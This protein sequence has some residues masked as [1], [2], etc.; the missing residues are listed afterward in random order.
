MIFKA[1]TGQKNQQILSSM[2]GKTLLDIQKATRRTPNRSHHRN[3]AKV[4]L[5]KKT[6]LHMCESHLRLESLGR[7]KPVCNQQIVFQGKFNVLL[8]KQ[9]LK[10]WNIKFTAICHLM[11]TTGSSK[12]NKTVIRNQKSINL[13]RLRNR[14][15]ATTYRVVF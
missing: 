2:M 7:N 13:V 15:L 6:A 3:R 12:R 9:V 1:D 8:K 10:H 5:E 14:E 11:K 4:A